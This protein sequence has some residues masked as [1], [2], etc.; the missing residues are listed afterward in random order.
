[1]ALWGLALIWTLLFAS[2]FTVIG[3]LRLYVAISLRY[4]SWGWTAVDG[5]V[6]LALGI[7]LCVEAPT[8][9]SWFLGF[10]LGIALVLRGWSNIMFAFAVRTMREDV[11]LRPAA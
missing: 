6:T 10:A 1:M 5:A 2:F 4:R 3:L 9:A 8:S 7:F 11:A